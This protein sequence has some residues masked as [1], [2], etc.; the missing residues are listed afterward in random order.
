MRGLII[1]DRKR[2][3]KKT[4]LKK[5]AQRRDYRLQWWL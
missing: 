5:D 4:P 1:K 2:E 3:V